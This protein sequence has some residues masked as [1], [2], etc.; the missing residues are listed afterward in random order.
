MREN[1]VDGLFNM[2]QAMVAGRLGVCR[3]TVNRLAKLLLNSKRITIY[4]SA[5]CT[6]GRPTIYTITPVNPSYTPVNHN[7]TPVKVDSNIDS[8]DSKEEGIYVTP[9]H[10]YIHSESIIG[11]ESVFENV[12]ESSVC[13][14]S[15]NDAFSG[16]ALDS[17]THPLA[18]GNPSLP[19]SGYIITL[20]PT[21]EYTNADLVPLCPCGEYICAFR[22]S[23]LK[24]KRVRVFYESKCNSC[25]QTELE[26]KYTQLL[27]AGKVRLLHDGSRVNVTDYA[28]RGG[29][30]RL[31]PIREL[32]LDR[33][34]CGQPVLYDLI[35]ERGAAPKIDAA[36]R[37]KK[38]MT[39]RVT[40]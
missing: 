7:Y 21:K 25:A 16:L 34:Q 20:D 15:T 26:N 17:Q 33:C 3:A 22:Y 18:N 10:T 5:K 27:K 40:V 1:S 23:E 9:T 24:D 37:C 38:C 31:I 12:S 19:P 6:E 39:E 13:G 35:A 32:A 4:E 14:D 29:V 8:I 36:S 28:G 11:A 2:P 30:L